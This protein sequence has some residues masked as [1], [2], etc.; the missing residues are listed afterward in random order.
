MSETNPP[1]GTD[2]NKKQSKPAEQDPKFAI[3]DAATDEDIE[4]HGGYYLSG[5]FNIE[6]SPGFKALENLKNRKDFPEE[7]YKIFI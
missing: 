7:R 3:L 1:N 4:S 6:T 2:T 5:L